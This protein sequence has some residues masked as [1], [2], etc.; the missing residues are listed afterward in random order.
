[1]PPWPNHKSYRREDS[2]KNIQRG[3]WYVGTSGNTNR[4]SGVLKELIKSGTSG[5]ENSS[6]PSTLS[7]KKLVDWKTRNPF[8]RISKCVLS[9]NCR[10]FTNYFMIYFLI[11]YDIFYRVDSKMTK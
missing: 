10:K 3:K 1:M 7:N 6:S 9:K 5:G 2:L 8:H 4:L 11:N